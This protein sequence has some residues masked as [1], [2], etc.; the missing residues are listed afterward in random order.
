LS[1]YLENV[2]DFSK[3]SSSFVEKLEIRLWYLVKYHAGSELQE[4]YD[5]LCW[6]VWREDEIVQQ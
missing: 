1:P 6:V 5:M 3:K 4:T 2:V